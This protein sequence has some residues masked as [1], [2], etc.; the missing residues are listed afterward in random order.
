MKKLFLT[1]ATLVIVI[2]ISIAQYNVPRNIVKIQSIQ[3]PNA[4]GLSWTSRE[5]NSYDAFFEE[6]GKKCLVRYSENAEKLS[7]Q[8]NS[9]MASLPLAA[10]QKISSVYP[11]YIPESVMFFYKKNASEQQ[12]V[13]LKNTTSHY[14]VFI[15]KGDVAYKLYFSEDGVLLNKPEPIVTK[16]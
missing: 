16:P 3:Y 8:K 11:D 13:F 9:D 14:Q 5:G 12:E 1:L 6:N 4:E 10:R 7:E 15:G 2:N